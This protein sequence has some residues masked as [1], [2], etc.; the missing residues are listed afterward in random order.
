MGVSGLFR[1]VITS[2][3]FGSRKP[4]PEIFQHALR[5]LH[6]S[7]ERCVYVGDSYDVDY[8]GARSVDIRPLL[9]DPR[10]EAPVPTADRLAS[11]LE[12]EAR[13]PD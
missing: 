13:L 11:I 3:G 12:L 7:P 4:A 8:R 6:V 1:R 2:V 10:C 5:V 9:I